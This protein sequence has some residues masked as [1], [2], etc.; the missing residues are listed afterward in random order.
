[1]TE[2]VVLRG[3]TWDHERGIGGLR[4]TA[5]AWAKREAGVR[6]EWTVRSLQAFADQ[7]V[8]VLAERFDLM[9]IDHP[10][11]GYAVARRCLVPLDEHLE[12]TYLEDQAASSVGAS[13]ASY[14]WEGHQW[15][16]A[17]DAAAQV[18]AYRPD[19]FERTGASV[20]R[21]WADVVALPEAGLAL[22]LP[23]I[24]VDAACAFLGLSNAPDGEPPDAEGAAEALATLRRLLSVAHGASPSWNPPTALETMAS[25]DDVAYIPLAFGYSNYARPRYRPNL[26]R[27]APP[28]GRGTLGGAGLAVSA[29]SP[30]V[31]DAVRYAALVAEG[32]TQRTIY[33]DG[34]GQPGHRSAWT[35]P[36]VNDAA[37]SFFADTLDAVDGAY[38]RPRHEGFLVFQD[39]AGRAIHAWLR[40]DDDGRP[41]IEELDRE[42][43]A[44]APAEAERGAAG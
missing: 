9:M 16:L 29:R 34:G 8:D 39:R 31:G 40:G 22:A 44:T 5:E 1:M 7:P 27:F 37:S 17:V 14:A 42:Y 30:R 32:I 20:P 6:V 13:H 23:A 10:S 38:L 43:R 36:A 28:P 21:T 33:F 18:A 12:A 19:L 24:P 4:A 41:L 26:I 15:A 35:E 11:I 2:P 3:I 25:S